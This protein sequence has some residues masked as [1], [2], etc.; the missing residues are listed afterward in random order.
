MVF[1]HAFFVDLRKEQK[2]NSLKDF[3]YCSYI[4]YVKEGIHY[5][6]SVGE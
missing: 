2:R 4:L 3:A 1:L 5:K 6:R